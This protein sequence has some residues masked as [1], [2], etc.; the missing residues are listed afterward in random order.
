MFQKAKQLA[1]AIDS[2]HLCAAGLNLNNSATMRAIN[3]VG[4]KALIEAM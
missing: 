4:I 2:I 1:V 3:M